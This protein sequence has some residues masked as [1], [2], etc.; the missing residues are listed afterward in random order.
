M[1]NLFKVGIVIFITVF[2]LAC[3]TNDIY[4]NSSNNNKDVYYAKFTASTNSIHMDSYGISFGSISHIDKGYE[5]S[6][7]K[8][9]GPAPK[10]SVA[11]ITAT[12]ANSVAIYISKNGGPYLLKATGISTARYTVDF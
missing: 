6:F 8:I 10:G 9:L 7:S 12:P 4:D 1:K 3:E 2:C 5:P 11:Y